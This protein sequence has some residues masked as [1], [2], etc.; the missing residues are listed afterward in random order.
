MEVV[1][2]A[3]WELIR[4]RAVSGKGLT[5]FRDVQRGAFVLPFL[6]AVDLFVRVAVGRHEAPRKGASTSSRPIVVCDVG[7]DGFDPDFV[8]AVGLAV[9]GFGCAFVF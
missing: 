1:F 2:G 9:L 4:L 5:A 8:H 7:P 6:G 3:I